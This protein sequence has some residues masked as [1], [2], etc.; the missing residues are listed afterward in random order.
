[1]VLNN[2]S[3]QLLER[4]AAGLVNDEK[5]LLIGETGCGKTMIAQYLANIFN[6]KLVVYNLSQNSDSTDLLG[7]YRPIDMKSVLIT[8]IQKYTKY[9]SK[10]IDLNKNQIFLKKIQEMLVKRNYNSIITNL[11]DSFP[12]LLR[13]LEQK[14]K[15]RL[16][17]KELNGLKDKLNRIKGELIV[18]K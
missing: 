12:A 14:Q 10:I 18:L 9:L 5:M 11:L 7:G 13:K 1:M 3:G 17:S 6:K 2:Y 4:L 8:V 15:N 16:D